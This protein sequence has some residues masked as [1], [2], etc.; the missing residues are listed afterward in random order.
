MDTYS[1]ILRLAG[2][3]VATASNGGAGIDLA[4]SR[5]FDVHLVDLCLPDMSGIEVVRDL[6]LSGVSDALVV[7]TAFP[8]LESSFDAAAAGADGYVD[9]PLFEEDVIAVVDQALTVPFQCGILLAIARSR[10]SVEGVRVNKWIH[11]FMRSSA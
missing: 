1:T 7:V 3:E 2:F 10:R 8:A 4:S 6:K 11:A 9:G 5:A